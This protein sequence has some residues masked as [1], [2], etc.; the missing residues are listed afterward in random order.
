MW[1]PK[2]WSKKGPAPLKR[3]R[4]DLIFHTLRAQVR[5]QSQAFL[6]EIRAIHE[7]IYSSNED[8]TYYIII[9]GRYGPYRERQFW[10]DFR[11]QPKVAYG[12]PNILRSDCQTN[13]PRLLSGVSKPELLKQPTMT[14]ACIFWM[15]LWIQSPRLQKVLKRF[16]MKVYSGR[17]PAPQ[18]YATQLSKTSKQDSTFWVQVR[19]NIH[20]YFIPLYAPQEGHS[21]NVPTES[22]RRSLRS[23]ARR[24]RP[25]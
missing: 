18:K 16:L 7:S 12:A 23:P 21:S 24:R 17:P 20:P 11:V 2:S 4:N 6:I 15:R 13:C 25:L 19:P 8:E 5:Q 14:H 9:K 1:T 10:S 22:T 3:A